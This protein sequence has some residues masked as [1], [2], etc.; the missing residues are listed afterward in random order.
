[1]TFHLS[2]RIPT[3]L[4]LTLHL[5]AQLLLTVLQCLPA[6]VKVQALHLNLNLAAWANDPYQVQSNLAGVETDSDSDNDIV[7][8]N[9]LD[10]VVDLAN[11]FYAEASWGNFSLAVTYTPILEVDYDQSTCDDNDEPETDD[12]EADQEADE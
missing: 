10:E 5:Q 7:E 8:I 4:A 12:E 3:F 6:T 1:M 9:I 2:P 11:D